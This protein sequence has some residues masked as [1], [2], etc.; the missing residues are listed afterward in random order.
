[1]QS[2]NAV[3]RPSAYTRD[4]TQKNGREKLGYSQA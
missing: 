4:E 3:F 2:Q 1:M